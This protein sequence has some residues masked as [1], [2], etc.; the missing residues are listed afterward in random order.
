M[1]L[2]CCLFISSAF[3]QTDTQKELINKINALTAEIKANPDEAQPYVERS[4]AVFMLNSLKPNQKWV[5]FTLADAMDDINRAVELKPEHAAFYGKRA[6]LRRNI[7]QDLRGAIT[8]MNTAID[9]QP[10]NPQWYF[11]RASYRKLSYGCADYERCADMGDQR[12]KE[13]MQS[14]CGKEL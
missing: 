12:C 8:D 13:M 14:V 2:A 5:P 4:E 7:H 10:D 1:V 9:L 11:Q 6:E 3:A